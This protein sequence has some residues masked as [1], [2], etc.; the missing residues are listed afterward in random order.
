M[1]AKVARKLNS[2]FLIRGFLIHCLL[3][4]FILY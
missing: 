1:Q 4:T 3:I 2:G